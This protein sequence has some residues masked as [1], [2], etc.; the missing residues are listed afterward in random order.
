MAIEPCPNPTGG[1]LGDGECVNALRVMR[2]RI[3]AKMPPVGIAANLTPAAQTITQ[4]T[5]W[6]GGAC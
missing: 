4:L 2:L 3:Y 5:K 6:P 1:K